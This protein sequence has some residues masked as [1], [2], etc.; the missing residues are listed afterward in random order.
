MDERMNPTQKIRVLIHPHLYRIRAAMSNLP[1][2]DQGSLEAL[3]EEAQGMGYVYGLLCSQYLSRV[4]K[5]KDLSG[6][7]ILLATWFCVL[8]EW[9]LQLL[10]SQFSPPS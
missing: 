8:E 7:F 1:D 5:A 3:V 2:L 10:E 4:A 6:R 9:H